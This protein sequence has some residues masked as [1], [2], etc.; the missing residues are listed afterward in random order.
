MQK[1]V[2][3]STENLL[4]DTGKEN[5]ANRLATSYVNEHDADFRALEEKAFKECQENKSSHGLPVK[6]EPVD[7]YIVVQNIDYEDEE[8]PTGDSVDSSK[9]N[10]LG[11][12]PLELS[13]AT[14]AP[15]PYPSGG[16]T[17]T[18]SPSKAGGVKTIVIKEEPMEIKTEK[19]CFEP[20]PLRHFQS[21]DASF[22]SIN[23]FVAPELPV[24]GYIVVKNMDDEDEE[25]PTGDTLDSSKGNPL[26]VFPL[27]LSRAMSALL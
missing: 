7:D 4:S 8:S 19:D 10:T 22:P 12:S 20:P 14:S 17:E 21:I 2:A 1:S 15:P 24:D 11:V 26:G 3:Q 16:R 18:Y 23:Q 9:G 27:E 6:G 25:S 13:R 5:F